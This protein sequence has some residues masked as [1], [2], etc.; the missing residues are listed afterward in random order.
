V[1]LIHK[2]DLRPT[3]LD[4]LAEWLPTRT[5]YSRP[6]GADLDRVAAYRFDDPDGEVGVET[7]LITAGA[8]P[9]LQIPLTYRAAPLAGA[10]EHLI[11]TLDHSV[12][13]KRWVYDACADPVYLRTL[14]HTILTGGRQADEV[15][16]TD[17]GLQRRDPSAMVRGSGD[18][19][20]SEDEV[21]ERYQDGDPATIVTSGHL[22]TIARVLPER[23][24]PGEAYT[25][26]G[27]WPGQDSE[28]CL[29][30]VTTR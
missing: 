9:V 8:G 17:N 16:E 29:A 14:L 2:A 20:A 3:K 23:S 27:R 6:A 10:D 1:A 30:S 26:I 4:L 5:W 15:I 22:I 13:G 7:L 24:V 19:V 18:G 28:L 11:G 12:L 21:A 25:L